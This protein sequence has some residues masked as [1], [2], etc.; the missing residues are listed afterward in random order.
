MKRKEL[1][2]VPKEIHTVFGTLHEVELTRCTLNIHPECTG[3]SDG[4][5]HY[6][7]AERDLITTEP[8]SVNHVRGACRKCYN[9]QCK[10]NRERKKSETTTLDELFS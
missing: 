2:P 6:S 4:S 5:D 9:M 3:Y 7:K 1:K 8:I 10:M